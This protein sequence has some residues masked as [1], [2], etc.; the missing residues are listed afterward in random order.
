[1]RFLVVDFTLHSHTV[2][3]SSCQ[4]TL[5]PASRPHRRPPPPPLLAIS[6]GTFRVQSQPLFRTHSSSRTPTPRRQTRGTARARS[7]FPGSEDSMSAPDM[8]CLR[9]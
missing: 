1:M 4:C 7:S 2:L 8:A 3:T 6:T 5:G 9:M